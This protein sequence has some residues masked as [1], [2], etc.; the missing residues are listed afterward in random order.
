MAKLFLKS[1]GLIL[2]LTVSFS[3][4]ALFVSPAKDPQVVLKSHYPNA[5]WTADTVVNRTGVE[6]PFWRVSENGNTVAYSFETNALHRVPAYSGEPVNMLVS[7]GVDGLFQNVTVLEHHEPILLVGIPESKIHVFTQ[8]YEQLSIADRIKVGGNKADGQI[9]LDGLSGA[10]VTVMVMN[11][12]ITRSATMLA[13]AL[14][15]I[16]ETETLTLPSTINEEIERQLTWQQLIGDGSIRRMMLRNQQ[17]DDAFIGT[18]GEGIDESPV[19]EKQE[20]FTDIYYAQVD[21]PAVGKNLLGEV[22]Y[23]WLKGTL[24]PNEHALVLL[25]N[26]Y[27]FKGSGYVRGGIFDRIQLLQNDLAISFRDLDHV[28]LQDIYLPDAPDFSEK[29]IFV[30]RDHHGFD[31]GQPWEFELLVRRQFGATDSVF[32]SFRAEYVA[33][34]DYV[35][36]PEPIMVKPELLLWQQVWLDRKVDIVILLAGLTL[37][38]GILFFQDV[39][40]RHPRFLHNLRNGFL[41]YTVVFIGWYTSGQISIVNV[42]TFLS[43]FMAGFD[44]Q[45]FLLDPIIFIMWVAVA[46]TGMMWGRGVF[47]GWLCPFGAAQ[48]LINH[49]ARLLKIPQYELPFAVQERLWAIKYLVLLAL[50]GLSMQSLALAETY[51]EIEPFKTTFLLKFSREWG[52]VL[53]AVLILASNLFQ[54]KTFCRYL[55]PLGAALSVPTNVK[56]FDWLKRRPECGQ[57][58]RVC[59]NECEIQAIEPDGTINQREC[60][61]CLDCQMTYFNDEKCPPLVLKAK[62]KNRKNSQRIEAVD[63]SS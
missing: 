26:G 61:Y 35:I 31:P 62:K 36:R 25:G 29:S 54:R 21:L 37:L 59:A 55:C 1:V 47:C 42:F 43:A 53:W 40:V 51:A 22:E 10:T 15:L 20:M 45:N 33:L 3:A 5:S 24:E 23:T 14:G 8:Q 48:E 17:V 32:T 12:G 52:Y 6:L 9:Q 30:I 4:H 58:C 18:E 11:V 57:P 7:I 13:R 19:D 63:I 46:V 50:F 41:I 27:S 28:R 34:D 49:V 2:L 39:L 16:E 44:W 60:H 38:L 56:L